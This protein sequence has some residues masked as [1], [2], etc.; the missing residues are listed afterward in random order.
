MYR[1]SN[2]LSENIRSK[3][4][5]VLNRVERAVDRP[6][7]ILYPLRRAIGSR[8][9]SNAGS[10]TGSVPTGASSVASDKPTASRRRPPPL[11]VGLLMI[12]VVSVGYLGW[13]HLTRSPSAAPEPPPPV[14]VIATTVQKQNFPIVPTGVGNV[15]ALNSA[16]V[17]SMVMEQIVS[18]DFKDG[19]F[20]RWQR[21]SD[22]PTAVR[23]H[24]DS[25]RRSPA[26][27]VFRPSGELRLG[28]RSRTYP[29]NRRKRNTM[30]MD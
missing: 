10:Q 29:A 13:R 26:T 23:G 14:P 15:T 1:T 8:P 30:L 5:E 17:H 9:M 6:R 7:L 4:A 24:L 25:R 27:H 2:T 16:T 20:V 3:A 28:L 22:S 19:Q 12:A 21:P 18:V 11:L